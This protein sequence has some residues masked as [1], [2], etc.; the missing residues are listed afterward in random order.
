[1]TSPQIVFINRIKLRFLADPLPIVADGC[2]DL[3]DRINSRMPG[4]QKVVRRGN[5]GF[6]LTVP[7]FAGYEHGLGRFI[8]GTALR[9]NVIGR[10]QGQL[11]PI[12]KGD[13]LT[14]VIIGITAQDIENQP[15]IKLPEGFHRLSKAMPDD[16]R[17]RIRG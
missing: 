7:V 12:P 11:L 1:M 4:K 17:R 8:A 2:F 5:A 6:E 16:F 13:V 14:G 3:L 15:T 10:R 9:A